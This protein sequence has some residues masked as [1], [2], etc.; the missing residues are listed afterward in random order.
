MW[1]LLHSAKR[2]LASKPVLCFPRLDQPFIVEVD[3][4]NHAV[5]GVLAQV[6]D[7]SKLHPVAYYSTAIQASQK[8]WSATTKEAFDLILAVRHWRVYLAGKSFV[9]NS[10]H[11]PLTHLRSQKD[12]RGK[13][14]R[15]IS[16]LKDFHNSIQYITG[17]NNVKVD[18]L[19]CNTAACHSQLSSEFESKIYAM[20]TSDK[21]FLHQSKEE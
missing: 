17:R 14:G 4:S 18:A 13:F 8:Q 11:N 21:N 3:A 15:W 2:H 1:H 19:S 12:P 20:F 9:L 5:C 16:E 6:F 7:D 10:D